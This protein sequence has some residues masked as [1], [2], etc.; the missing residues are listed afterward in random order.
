MHPCSHPWYGFI[1]Y[2]MPNIR[3]F[4]FIYNALGIYLYKLSLY[5]R[6]YPVIYAFNMLTHTFI[7]QKLIFSI[8]LCTSAFFIIIVFFRWFI[9]FVVHKLMVGLMN[10][11]RP[12]C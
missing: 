1:L 5:I 4:H 12:T 2:I 8:D 6:I 11:Y 7:N 3:A 10:N 9:G